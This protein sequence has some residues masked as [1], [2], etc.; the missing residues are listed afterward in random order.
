MREV[1]S[2]S[3]YTAA[4]CPF[5]VARDNGVNKCLQSR[6]NHHHQK[7]SLRKRIS[8]CAMHFFRLAQ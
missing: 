7:G 5:S 1:R 6:R 8:L 3:S 4:S 2:R